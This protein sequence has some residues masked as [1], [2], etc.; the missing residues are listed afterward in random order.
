MIT[1]P[2]VVAALILATSFVVLDFHL[3]AI[4]NTYITC[5]SDIYSNS[6]WCYGKERGEMVSNSGQM[7]HMEDVCGYGDIYLDWDQASNSMTIYDA[8]NTNIGSCYYNYG[9][10]GNCIYPRWVS[11]VYDCYTCITFLCG[12]IN[13][14]RNYQTDEES[15]D[16]NYNSFFIAGRGENSLVA[17][18][19][20]ALV[21]GLEPENS[22]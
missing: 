8:G 2:K 9:F 1:L 5:P 3:M 14:K 11:S 22:K 19:P 15:S 21:Q 12:D 6:C 17:G 10:A 7:V 20:T 16:G 13:S 18:T 4:E